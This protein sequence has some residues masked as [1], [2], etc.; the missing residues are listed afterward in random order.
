MNIK[1]NHHFLAENVQYFPFDLTNSEEFR[2]SQP[3]TQIQMDEAA[4]RSGS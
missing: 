4:E 2:R 1:E 3:D